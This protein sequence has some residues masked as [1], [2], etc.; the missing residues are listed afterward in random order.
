MSQFDDLVASRKAWLNDILQP[1]CRS[2]SVK[3]LRQAEVEWTDI[4]GKVPP[5]KT[6]WIWAW[7][8]FPELV[9][10]TLGIDESEEVEV[11]LPDGRFARGYPDAR[12][13]LQGKLVLWGTD[14]ERP[15]PHECGPFSIDEIASV[16][17]LRC[18]Q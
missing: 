7:S 16:K 13:S 3:A 11:L 18:E 2:A 12:A 14:S 1:W 10:E 8:R 9:H 5:E 4:A 15:Q 6:L 17:R